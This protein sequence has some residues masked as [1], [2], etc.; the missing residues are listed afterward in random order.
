MVFVKLSDYD[1]TTVIE[2]EER[3]I[4][5]IGTGSDDLNDHFE[6]VKGVYINHL[7]TE[8]AI[9]KNYQSNKKLIDE[10]GVSWELYR[11]YGNVHRFIGLWD[12]LRDCS[13]EKS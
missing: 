8:Q 10:L 12:T 4:E 1:A 7:E 11:D 13:N 9:L 6:T 5:R 2:S 3:L